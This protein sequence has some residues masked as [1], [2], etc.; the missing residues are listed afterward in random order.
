[1]G[2]PVAIACGISSPPLLALGRVNCGDVVERVSPEDRESW[3]S[4]VSQ[5]GVN[6]GLIGANSGTERTLVKE[7]KRGRM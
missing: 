5:D 1:M 4:V 2:V 7:V 3:L 6:G